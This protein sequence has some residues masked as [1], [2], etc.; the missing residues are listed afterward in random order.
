MYP[1]ITLIMMYAGLKAFGILG[2]FAFPIIS[3]IVKN[4]ND[5]G[6]ISLWKYPEGVSDGNTPQKHGLTAI[7]D[8]ITQIASEKSDKTESG[9]N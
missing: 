6:T 3:I 8:H 1:L 5:S 9:D 4:L 7:K 2:L